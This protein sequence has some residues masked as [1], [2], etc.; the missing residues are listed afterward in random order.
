LHNFYNDLNYPG[1]KDREEMFL[2][3]NLKLK[4][5]L[6][7]YKTIRLARSYFLTKPDRINLLAK[8]LKKFAGFPKPQKWV[9]IVGCYNS[10]T[11]LLKKILSVHSQ[12]SSFDG[13]GV[14]FTNEL[15]TPE[16]LG[17]SRMWCQVLDKVRL[18]ENDDYINAEE[19]KKDWSLIFN[20]RKTVYL[21]KSIVNSARMLWLQKNFENSYFIFMVRNGYAV[22]EGIRRKAP[23]GRWG[24]QQIKYKKDSYPIELC[25]KQWVVNNQLIEKDSEK[26]NFFKKIYYEDFCKNPHKIIRDIYEFLSL[27]SELNW[28]TG[29]KWRVSGIQS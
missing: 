17:W 13:E 24:I 11:S 26:I 22:A 28:S 1:I 20:N 5:L 18:T 29:K 14:F 25:A 8:V 2:I 10:G 9:F 7:P 27:K 19:V 12:I 23:I 4:H 6:S 21:E 15:I 16:E 3:I